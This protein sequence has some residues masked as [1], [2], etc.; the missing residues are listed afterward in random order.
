MCNARATALDWNGVGTS[1][2][3]R[4]QLAM[5]YVVQAGLPAKCVDQRS[6]SKVLQQ[7]PWKSPEVVVRELGIWPR[8]NA[9]DSIIADKQRES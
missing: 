2:D 7:W 1:D 4:L 6:L 9:C 8:C 3:A 5:M